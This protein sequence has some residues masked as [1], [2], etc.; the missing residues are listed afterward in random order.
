MCSRPMTAPPPTRY[1]GRFAPSP[2]GPLHL[3]SL[4]CALASYLDARQHKGEWLLRIEDIDPDREP[5]GATESILQCLEAHELHWDRSV[6]L[7]SQESERYSSVLETLMAAGEVYRC[8]CTR[9][10][11]AGLSGPYDGHCRRSQ[12][13]Q[14]QAAVLRLKVSPPSR[15]ELAPTVFSFQ[16]RVYGEQRKDLANT[17]GDFVVH[18]KYGL[19]AYQLVVVLDDIDQGVTDVVRGSDL[20]STTARQLYLYQLLD[21]PVP[22]YG[23]VP[24]VTDGSGSK[25]S[26]QNHAPALNP[27]AASANLRSA[28]RHLG[29]AVPKELDNAGATQ[30]IEYALA[31]FKLEHLTCSTGANDVS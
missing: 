28:M 3:G 30:L 14:Q 5:P 4:T 10:R 8:T 12:P 1:V 19:F 11:L 15:P 13:P 2:S 17:C 25:L 27:S 22:R 23:H 16:D 24:V 18:R 31:T 20:L 21:E 29:L 9:K 7:Q 6:R 26:K